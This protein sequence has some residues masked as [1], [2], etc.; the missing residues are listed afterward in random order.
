MSYQRPCACRTEKAYFS[1]RGSTNSRSRQSQQKDSGCTR[2]VSVPGPFKQGRIVGGPSDPHGMQN[3][4]PD[5]GKRTNCDRMALAFFALAAVVR[6]RPGLGKRRSPGKLVEGVA[7]RLDTGV[8]TMSFG[9]VATLVHHRGCACQSLQ[10][11]SLLI[12]SPIIPDF[13]QQPRSQSLPSSG[14]RAEDGGVFMSAKK[15]FDLLIIA[16]NLLDEGQQ[17]GGQSSHQ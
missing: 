14:K 15:A 3:T 2:S 4:Q 10:I 11:P 9:K 17:L 5:M 8:T 12:T 16:G 1:A 7:Q 6:E 13:C